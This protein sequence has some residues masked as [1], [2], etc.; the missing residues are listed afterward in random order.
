MQRIEWF[1]NIITSKA[2]ASPITTKLTKSVWSFFSKFVFH[3]VGFK[4]VHLFLESDAVCAGCNASCVRK[5]CSGGDCGWFWGNDKCHCHGCRR[6]QAVRDSSA[7]LRYVYVVSGARGVFDYFS[8]NSKNFTNFVG[9][10]IIFYDLVFAWKK[11]PSSRYK[12]S[13]YIL[14]R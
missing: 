6:K 8:I 5:H 12:D 7:D 13:E 14:D 4:I 9:H 1:K 10:L 2:N 11:C 3:H